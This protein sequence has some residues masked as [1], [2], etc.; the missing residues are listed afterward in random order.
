MK[1]VLA[2]ALICAASS[3]FA[4]WDLFPVKEAGKGEAKLGVQYTIPAEKTSYLGLNLGARYSIIEGLEAA[5]LLKGDK[6]GFVLTSDYDGND[7]KQTGL[8][9]PI[10]GVRYWLPLGLGIFADVALPFGGEKIV[11]K[12]PDVGLNAGLQYSTKINEQLSIG[13]EA[14]VTK[15]F[16]DPSSGLNLGI[17][18][19]VDYSLG[20]ITPWLSVDFAKGIIKSDDIEVAGIVIQ[21]GE[22]APMGIGLSVGVTYDISEKLYVDAGF[23]IGL[24]GD[25]YKNYSPKTINANV[26]LNF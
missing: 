24:A 18:A 12:E 14:A 23:W 10:I 7:L 6:G 4:S 8:D 19:E 21:K 1:K 26:G 22:A 25:A 11:G 15:V 2:V 5:V 17:A 20:S 16:S 9:K 3:A 13:S